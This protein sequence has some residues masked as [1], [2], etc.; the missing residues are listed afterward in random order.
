MV[1]ALSIFTNE[2]MKTKNYL[3]LLTLTVFTS[4]VFT[5]CGDEEAVPSNNEQIEDMINNGNSENISVREA[6]A[7]EDAAFVGGGLQFK[8]TS[9]ID[10]TVYV[11]GTSKDVHSETFT[12]GFIIP[13]HITCNG[14]KYTVISIGEG[15]FSNFSKMTSIS[16][17]ISLQMIGYQAFYNCSCL[18]S[19]SI[20]SSVNSIGNLAFEG[21]SSLTSVVI[22]NSVSLIGYSAFKDCSGLISV[23]IPTSVTSIGSSAFDG[24]TNLTSLEIPNSVTTIG[25]NAFYNCNKLTSVKISDLIAWC[26]IK[27]N[28]TYSNPLN[29]AHDLYLN[30]ELLKEL[31]IPNSITEIKNYTFYNCSSLTSVVIGNNITSIGTCAFDYCSNL[32]SVDISRSVTTIGERVFH[33]CYKLTNIISRAVTPPNL[34]GL[35]TF[36][37]VSYTD[38]AEIKVPRASIETYKKDENWKNFKNIV[39]IY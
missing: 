35:Y 6:T 4:F 17:P 31:I 25:E 16:L 36:P 20:P 29:Y 15:V 27:F 33:N 5:S 24:C 18:T 26:E 37:N 8:V 1:H 38:E 21:C 23:T 22:P 19:I 32:V 2:A 12:G 28:N 30:G 14:I 10:K 13:A 3:F 11:C 9:Y 34:H 39:P 7:E